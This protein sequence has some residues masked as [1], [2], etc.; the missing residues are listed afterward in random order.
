M[1][2]LFGI[3]KTF[4][5]CVFRNN[6]AKQ[7]DFIPEPQKGNGNNC[8]LSISFFYS[9]TW[10]RCLKSSWRDPK[11]SYKVMYVICLSEGTISIQVQ[12]YMYDLRFVYCLT[13]FSLSKAQNLWTCHKEVPT[14]DNSRSLNSIKGFWQ[15]GSSNRIYEYTKMMHQHFRYSYL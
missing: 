3:F 1:I 14:L 13:P 9:P 2:A 12:R 11:T 4:C 15:F 5:F 10:I 6:L 7:N 8:L